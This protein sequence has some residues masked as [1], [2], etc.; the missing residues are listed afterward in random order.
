MKSYDLKLKGGKVVVWDGKNGADASQRYKDAH[1]GS[2]VKEADMNTIQLKQE[3]LDSG[4]LRLV[5][6]PNGEVVAEDSEGI[7]YQIDCGEEE[8]G[9]T[10]GF[11][12]G[13]RVI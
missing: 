1:P 7:Q 10:G 13:G 12:P 4:E 11:V 2:V 9:D 6:L 5:E 3:D 8:D